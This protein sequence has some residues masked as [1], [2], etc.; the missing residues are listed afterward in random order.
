M[1]ESIAL[2]I[3]WQK[4]Y[5]LLPLRDVVVFPGMVIPLFVGR[6]RSIEAIKAAMEADRHIVVAAQFDPAV[7][8]PQAGEIYNVGCVV[9]V[10]QVL[11]LPDGAIKALV[12]GK[13]RARVKKYVG[14]HNR[15]TVT[16][17]RIKAKKTGGK[18]EIEAL[19]KAARSLFERYAKLSSGITTEEVNSISMEE[20]PDRFVD[21]I[22]AGLSIKSAEKQRLLEASTTKERLDQL[23]ETIQGEIEV[24]KIEPQS[25][26]KSQKTDGKV[27]T[28]LLS[29]RA[30][31]SNPERASGRG[32]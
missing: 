3:D 27:A 9:Q 6:P 10:S 12:E 23:I 7:D 29:D 26:V 24:Q 18:R 32:R 20:S 2:P 22:S 16:I 15:L 14:E 28:G 21:I 31:Q 1:D 19:Y 17:E 30:D 8:E 13:E 11:N 25:Q 5:P 4:E